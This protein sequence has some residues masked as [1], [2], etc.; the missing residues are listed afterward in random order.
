MVRRSSLR[1]A[2]LAVLPSVWGLHCP[3][4]L[5]EPVSVANATQERRSAA[6]K[7]FEAGDGLYEGGS[8][9][10]ALTAF[11]ASYE[12]V[13]S[14]NT[15]LMMARCLRELGR[16]DEAFHEFDG[17]IELAQQSGGR[18]AEAAEAARAERDAL[19]GSIGYVVVTAGSG[20]ATGF[21]LL[22]QDHGADDFGKPIPVV[23]REVS[24]SW[25]VNGAVAEE[26]SITV[27]PGAT[28]PVE[29]RPPARAV[30]APKKPPPAPVPPRRA[31][32]PEPK[33]ASLRPYAFVAA[34]VGAVGFA[35]FTVFGLKS[36]ST[37]A[38][39]KDACPGGACPP[40]RLDDIDAGRR[41]QMIANIGLAVGAAGLTTGVVLYLLSPSTAESERFTAR[42]GPTS[43]RL[44][45]T[46]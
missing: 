13:Q 39:L 46:F 37:Y 23:A 45:G 28:A 6:Q 25:I 42:I 12:L 41:D 14:A 21:R 3:L 10:E 22:G 1:A 36:R 31:A 19:S 7:T 2:V 24:I 32:R 34:G 30:A 26:R 17:T 43:V 20:G 11:R 15:R 8:F 5:A 16:V 33:P 38:S 44:R 40:E 35:T 4:A 9:E 27:A 29:P 18:Y